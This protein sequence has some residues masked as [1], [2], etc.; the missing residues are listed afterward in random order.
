MYAVQIGA[1][2]TALVRPEW[3]RD[4]R[5]SV[6]LPLNR[7]LTVSGSIAMVRQRLGVRSAAHATC[8][9]VML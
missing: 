9:A 3:S 7:R 4:T 8:D 5:A 2:G 6:R 1:L